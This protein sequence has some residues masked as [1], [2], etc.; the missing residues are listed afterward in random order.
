MQLCSLL[1][2]GE[3]GGVKKTQTNTKSR[4]QRLKNNSQVFCISGDMDFIGKDKSDQ[5]ICLM[6]ASYLQGAV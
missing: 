1:G 3:R 4:G 6:M 5:V 2:G